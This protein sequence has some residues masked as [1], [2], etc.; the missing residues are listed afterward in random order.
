VIFAKTLHGT[1]FKATAIFG[2]FFQSKK[3]NSTQ[4]PKRKLMKKL[5]YI[6]IFSI[7]TAMSVSSCTEQ[8][9]KPKEGGGG[10]T[11]NDPKG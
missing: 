3:N 10:G 9:V 11:A 1:G 2:P 5:I 8:E 4:K 7:I 6:A